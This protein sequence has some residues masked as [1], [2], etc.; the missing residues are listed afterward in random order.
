MI[1]NNSFSKHIQ[2]L[3]VPAVVETVFC[4]PNDLGPGKWI[5][6]K[7]GILCIVSVFALITGSYVSMK[8]IIHMYTS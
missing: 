2:G 3:M 5:L 1:D 6:I 7:N 4:Y 8:E